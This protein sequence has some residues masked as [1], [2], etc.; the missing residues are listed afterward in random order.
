MSKALK[1]L[2]A[3]DKFRGSLSASQAAHAIKMGILADAKDAQISEY[4]LTDGGDGF[5]DTISKSIKDAKVIRLKTIDPTGQVLTAKCALLDEN[6]ALVGLTEASGI[7]LVSESERN[8]LKLTNIGTGQILEKLVERGYKTI[9]I[10]V[11]GSAT[12]DGGIGLLIPLGFRFLDK[13]GKDIEPNG[14]GLA[15][16]DK[17]V[18][19][20]KKFTTKFIVATDVDNKLLGKTGAALGYAA[21]KGASPEDAQLLEQ[22]MKKLTEVAK[23][24]FGKSRSEERFSRNAERLRIRTDDFPRRKARKRFRPFRKIHQPRRGNK[25]RKHRHNRRRRIRLHGRARQRAFCARKAGG[26][27]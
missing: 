22:N 2:V 24:C 14:A 9:I 8:P 20:E 7:N 16:L 12:N 13:D 6:T 17:I 21:Q 23:K 19:P 27:I 18:A 11:G 1:F 10:G 15:N 3:P 25:E 26:K 5:V 4:T